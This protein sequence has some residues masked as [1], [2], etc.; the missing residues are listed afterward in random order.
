MCTY[1][2]DFQCRIVKFFNVVV[3]QRMVDHFD[4]TELPEQHGYEQ[5]DPWRCGYGRQTM[6]D[7]IH[8][9]FK[10]NFRFV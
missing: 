9:V 2:F 4:G 5:D 7:R 1:I 8:D 6:T 3:L 10:G